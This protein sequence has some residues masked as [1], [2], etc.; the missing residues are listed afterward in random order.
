MRAR[1]SQVS[2]PSFQEDEL[3]FT[4]PSA[5]AIYRIDDPATFPDANAPRV[6]WAWDEPDR[7]FLLEVKD[8]ES[9]KT[10]AF[11]PNEPER[12]ASSLVNDLPDR[13]AAKAVSTIRLKSE[14]Q[15]KP[16]T[17]LAL[18]CLS[19]ATAAAFFA[20]RIVIEKEF[21]KSGIEASA[22]VLNLEQWND[23]LQPRSV[24]RVT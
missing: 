21:A 11:N 6:D 7:H 24:R 1:H 9:S 15:R 20:A 3:L 5:T 22:L 14:C 18:I 10:K 2:K 23:V 16:S 17:Y 8:P 19:K 13:L 4:V 12:T